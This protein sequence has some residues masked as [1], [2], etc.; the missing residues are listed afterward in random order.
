MHPI[1]RRHLPS[2][3]T[4]LVA[5]ALPLAPGSAAAQAVDAV[6]GRETPAT[7]AAFGRAAPAGAA[8]E[9]PDRWEPGADR[10]RAAARVRAKLLAGARAPG[11]RRS[12]G[13]GPRRR[14]PAPMHGASPDADVDD[15]PHPLVLGL[16]GI[17]ASA[18]GM[19]GGFALGAEASCDDPDSAGLCALGGGLMGAAIGT[20]VTTPL[21]VHLVNGRRGSWILD[22]LASLGYGALAVGIVAALPEDEDDL[23][24]GI[25]ALTIPL[26]QTIGSVAVEK[27][28]AAGDR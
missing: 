4:L 3:A 7:A 2:V 28:T 20:T 22:Q 11:P 13:A 19:L 5:V 8:A 18:A 15:G 21:A 6:P 1:P 14:P 27:G 17:G 23:E 26:G 10:Y 9:P 25:V 12:A 24:Q 16:V